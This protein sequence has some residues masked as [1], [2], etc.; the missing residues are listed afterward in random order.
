[1]HVY[2]YPVQVSSLLDEK[3]QDELIED[4]AEE[5]EEIRQE[6]YESL[7]VIHVISSGVCEYC[8]FSQKSAL[9]LFGTLYRMVENSL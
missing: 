6:Y 1:M 4:V 3:L 9:K 5:Y 8:T 7:T 2:I